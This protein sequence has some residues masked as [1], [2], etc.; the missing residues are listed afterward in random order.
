MLLEYY[1]STSLV[2]LFEVLTPMLVVHR[3]QV[4]SGW[5][6][7][8]HRPNRIVGSQMMSVLAQLHGLGKLLRT[9]LCSA[10]EPRQNVRSEMVV[11]F[12]HLAIGVFDPNG[13]E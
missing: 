5:K 4:P 10:F 11:Q 13:K 1:S 2:A 6:E 3:G 12:R 7:V 8:F 9:D